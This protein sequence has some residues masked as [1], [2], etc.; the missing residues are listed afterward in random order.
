MSVEDSNAWKVVKLG[1][2][3]SRKIF[4]QDR[5]TREK[6]RR[7]RGTVLKVG[8]KTDNWCLKEH[9]LVG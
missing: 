6:V 2:P 8:A 4:L 3:R 9:D 5:S 7:M 1:K